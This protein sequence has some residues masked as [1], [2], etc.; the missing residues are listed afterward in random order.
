M[1]RKRST[2]GL[3]H[4]LLK[5]QPNYFRKLVTKM[6]KSLHKAHAA[7]SAIGQN[8]VSAFHVIIKDLRASAEKHRQVAVEANAQANELADL[9]DSANE[10]ANAAERQANSIA[11]LV[12]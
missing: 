7:A 8:A 9:R 4:S 5:T 3:S 1:A 10:A 12:S 11:A 2:Y 6:A